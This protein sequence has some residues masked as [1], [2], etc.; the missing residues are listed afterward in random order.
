MMYTKKFITKY[1]VGV[2]VWL[3]LPQKIRGGYKIARLLKLLEIGH[4]NALKLVYRP[5]M[6]LTA[7]AFTDCKI[8]SLAHQA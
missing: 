5:G 2:G 8:L 7:L 6:C 1:A 4:V 3:V